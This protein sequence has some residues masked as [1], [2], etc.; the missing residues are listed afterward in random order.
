MINLDSFGFNYPQI[1][2]TT[3]DG[4]LVDLAEVV[5]KDMKIPLAEVPTDGASADSLSF[6]N[7][8]I[9]SITFHGL[10]GNWQ[11]YLHSS[12]DKLENV[13]VSSVF[14]G[15]QYV[16]NYLT[17]VDSNTCNAFRK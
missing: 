13:N 11:K 4:K 15:Y 3:S 12:N 6:K 1:M 17:K 10:N 14:I 9:P 8:K 16:L 5:A 2:K 7:H